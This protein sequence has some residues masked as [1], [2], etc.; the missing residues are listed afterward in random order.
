MSKRTLGLVLIVVGAVAVVV[1]LAADA[2]GIGSYPGINGT[3]LLGLA[4]G[5]IVALVGIWL[6]LS[7]PNQKK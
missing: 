3:Q 1:S 4:I 5:V 7:K 6:G 2:L